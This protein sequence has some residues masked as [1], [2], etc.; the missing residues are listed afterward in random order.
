MLGGYH[1]LK[2]PIGSGYHK[3][4]KLVPLEFKELPNI[5]SDILG[6]AC[7]SHWA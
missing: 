2:T 4:L 5:C 3:R 1:F 6:F 7:L